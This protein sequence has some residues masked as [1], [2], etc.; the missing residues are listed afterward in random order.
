MATS[1]VATF[2]M[3]TQSAKGTAATTGFHCGVTQTDGFGEEWEMI[4]KDAEH[5]CAAGSN[6][7]AMKSPSIR[8]Y[9]TVA[10]STKAYL[11]PNLIGIMLR[12]LGFAAATSGTTILTHVFTAAASGA[13][14]YCTALSAMGAD[15]GA[16]L[17]R[18]AV[19][20]KVTKL[21]INAD[22]KGVVYSSEFLGLSSGDAL[23]TETKTDE[24]A[25]AMMPNNG[26][27]TLSFD[28]GGTPVTIS[29]NAT[30]PPRGLK[31][32]FT[33]P[34][35]EDDYALWST[36]LGSLLRSTGI[37]AEGSFDSM[38][39][40]WANYNRL[41]R[42]G[43]S[44]VAPSATWLPC[45][46][47]WKFNTAEFVSGATPYSL[48]VDI[49]RAQVWLDPKN[50]D[51]NGADDVRWSA[52]WKCYAGTATPITFTLINATTTY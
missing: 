32:S 16:V 37:A 29:S 2:K 12:G 33:N 46:L 4:D 42:G 40:I 14:V 51:N 31:A 3:A 13:D 24:P 25:Y 36:A 50:F 34:V 22:S 1:R 21:D 30:N 38:P 48:Q 43:A 47:Q 5:G 18:K 7:Y 8:T 26:T 41:M 20:C 11:Y 49:P 6:V 23:G 17:E 15:S 19:D 35:F 39:V 52:S 10:G 28:P 44:G 27:F 9:Y 45:S